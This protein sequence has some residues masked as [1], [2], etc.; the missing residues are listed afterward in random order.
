[1]LRGRRECTRY[2]ACCSLE[3]GVTGSSTWL[4]LRAL[5]M[6]EAVVWAGT[7]LPESKKLAEGE[8]SSCHLLLFEQGWGNLGDMYCKNAFLSIWSGRK[9]PHP[10]FE[11][12][13]K[14]PSVRQHAVFHL[15][16]FFILQLS[17]VELSLGL[18]YPGSLW[19]N[20]CGA[21][22]HE[23]ILCLRG[24]ALIFAAVSEHRSAV[25]PI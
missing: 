5:L 6:L 16:G 23:W 22:D 12:T 8:F 21:R 11:P 13:F 10:N 20:I 24:Q 1:M 15:S 2:R 3:L 9:T 19:L 25:P 18:K 14:A 7:L 17:E 4:S